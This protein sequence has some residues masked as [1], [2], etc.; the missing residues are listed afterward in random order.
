MRCPIAYLCGTT[1]RRAPMAKTGFL[2]AN[3]A[4]QPISLVQKPGF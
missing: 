2:T 3:L 4:S 1:D